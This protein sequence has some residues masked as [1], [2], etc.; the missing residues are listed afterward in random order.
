MKNFYRYLTGT[1]VFL[2]AALIFAGCSMAVE[3]GATRES[4][5]TLTENTWAD[6][7]ITPKREEQWFTFTATANTHYLHVSFGTLTHL[8]VQVYDS[9]NDPVG[10]RTD[11]SGSDSG[12]T[13][14]T[15]T[16]GKA[17]YIKVTPS[18]GSGAYRIAFNT[19]QSPPL[20]PGT[21][22]AAAALTENAWT[23]GDITSSINEQWFQFTATAATQ[24]IHVNFGTLP[25]LYIQLYDH[26][27]SVLG[28]QTQLPSGNDNKHTSVIVTIGQVYYIKVTP[29]GSGSGTYRIAFNKSDTAP[30]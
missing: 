9:K 5:I 23:G 17:Y 21:L 26:N 14:L 28:S 25:D 19:T 8:Y 10:A 20:P 1:A 3:A 22:T 15:V 29:S 11:F 7:S 30:N 18:S 16:S 4:A 6:G 24:Y 27:G 2:A 12:S 13:L